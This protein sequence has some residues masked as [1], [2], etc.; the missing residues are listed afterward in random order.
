MAMTK[1]QG[2]CKGFGRG[3]SDKWK[4]YQQ[5]AATIKGNNKV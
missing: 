3:C 4:E 2:T 1:D 5:Q